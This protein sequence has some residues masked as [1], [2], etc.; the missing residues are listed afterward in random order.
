MWPHF[1]HCEP[2]PS[3]LAYQPRPRTVWA[4]TPESTVFVCFSVRACVRPRQNLDNASEKPRRLFC[5]P[6]VAFVSTNKTHSRR[7]RYFSMLHHCLHSL[8]R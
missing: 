5:N 1:T 2:A 6:K 8:L 4:S 3:G 7:L